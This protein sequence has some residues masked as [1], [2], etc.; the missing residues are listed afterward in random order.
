MWMD[1]VNL[2]AVLTNVCGRRF[3]DASGVARFENENGDQW[4]RSPQ[5]TVR[6]HSTVIFLTFC[7]AVSVL[8]ILTSRTPSLKLALASSVR[9]S[10]GS[11]R[12]RVKDP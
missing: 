1:C 11:C 4:N 2:L 5:C 12:V 6:Y 7:T 8:G 3:A 9:V 10:A